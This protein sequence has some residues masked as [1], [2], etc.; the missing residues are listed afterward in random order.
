MDYTPSS[1]QELQSEYFVPREHAI[2]ALR[3]V[4]KLRQQVTPLLFISEIRT[5]AADTLWMSPC[6]Q[7]NSV[8]IHFTWKQNWPA[9][10]ELLFQIEAAL[11]PFNARPHWG[12]LFVMKP[13]RLATLYKKRP[14][15]QKLLRSFDPAGKFSNA[16]LD[17]YI[18][19]S[20]P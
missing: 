12:K 13:G 20:L 15:F 16:F 7:Q 17:D 3:K 19:S 9:V 18:F 8:A 2:A 4:S 5:I 14:E 6:C 11:T 10:R 1:G